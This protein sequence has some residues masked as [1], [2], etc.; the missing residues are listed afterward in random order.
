MSL[1]GD[2]L[3][4]IFEAVLEPIYQHASARAAGL[5]FAATL[6]TTGIAALCV[7]PDTRTTVVFIGG[8]LSALTGLVWILKLWQ[9]R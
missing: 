4:S 8:L 3:G 5:I 6:L 2:I 9:E 7:D 1:L